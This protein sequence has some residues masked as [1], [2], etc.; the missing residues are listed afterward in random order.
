[1][2][3]IMK[4]RKHADTHPGDD[5]YCIRLEL[6]EMTEREALAA[7]DVIQGKLYP[8]INKVALTPAPIIDADQDQRD[9]LTTRLS[10]RREK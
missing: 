3:G 4:F 2:K 6:T 9:Q 10:L 8:S 1:M 5:L 7:T